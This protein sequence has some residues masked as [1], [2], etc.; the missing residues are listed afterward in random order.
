MTC[1]V[2]QGSV[3]GPLLYVLYTSPVGYFIRSH[4]LSFHLYAGD[5]QLYTSF[6]F[7]SQSDIATAKSLI[8]S[9]VSDVHILMVINKLN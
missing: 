5:Q 9:C 1:D 8:E 7:D 4:G 3:L 2:P 6:F